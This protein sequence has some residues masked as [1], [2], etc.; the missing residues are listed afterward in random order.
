MNIVI[1]FG[2][3]ER[4][5]TLISFPLYIAVLKFRALVYT[6]LKWEVQTKCIIV[7]SRPTFPNG[8]LQRELNGKRIRTCSWVR[9]GLKCSEY[10]E[11]C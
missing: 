1:I 4:L 11:N 6:F 9:Y 7:I 10:C 8:L 2:K 5:H 3:Y